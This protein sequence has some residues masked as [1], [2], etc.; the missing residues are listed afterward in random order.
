[1]M[2]HPSP[3]ELRDVIREPDRFRPA[4]VHAASIGAGIPLRVWH[5]P[6]SP[7]ARVSVARLE[8]TDA[9][10]LMLN[11]GAYAR[12]ELAPAARL[13][14]MSAPPGSSVRASQILQGPFQGH[15]LIERTGLNGG[16]EVR[17]AGY[18]QAIMRAERQSGV[19]WDP[20]AAYVLRRASF[21]AR[22]HVWCAS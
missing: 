22:K 18:T 10:S 7:H 17:S 1:M 9:W 3:A 20:L 2:F 15:T 4:E 12:Q 11:A 14:F 21:C 5:W 6:A 8:S 19:R 16:V 13:L